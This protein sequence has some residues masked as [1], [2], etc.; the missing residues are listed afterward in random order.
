[1]RAAGGAL[2]R[3]A[4]GAAAGGPVEVALVHRPR[5]D[6]WS[7]PKGRLDPGEQ[8]LAAAAR[9]VQEETGW[10]S[11]LGRTLGE[12]RYRVVRDGRQ[13]DK[14]V[15]W[16]AARARDAGARPVDPAEVD[17]VRWLAPDDAASLLTA[18]RDLD[19]L[20]LLVETGT[21]TTTVVLLR[22]GCAGNRAGW[23]GAD[24]ARPLD[25]QGGRQ[26]RALAGLL[27]AYDPVRVLAAAPLRCRQ[28]VAPLA[29]ACGLA[30]E[31]DDLL[32]DQAWVDAPQQVL[33]RVGEL[34]RGDG[35]VVAASQGSAVPGV[36]RA[37][38][39]QSGLRAPDPRTPKGAGW[40]LTFRDGRLVAL[41]PLAAPA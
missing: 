7:L 40:A 15:Q 39:G 18:G 12:S 3:P 22:H 26:A 25:A 34:G 33:E 6:D 28:T 19:V 30:L 32:G 27:P 8:P 21:W 37:L 20:R 11:A 10:R 31:T 16:W 5:Y 1:M 23:S 38:A 4:D 9:E 24:G 35:A 41:D 13:R 36:V 2:W 17:E 14:T 29:D